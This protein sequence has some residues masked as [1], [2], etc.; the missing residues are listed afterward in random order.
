M[1]E[2]RVKIGSTH[3]PEGI[4]RDLQEAARQ[5]FHLAQA[6]VSDVTRIV[7]IMERETKEEE[8]DLSPETV[9]RIDDIVQQIESLIAEL[10]WTRRR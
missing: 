6:V 2:Y 5:G 4:E 7:L 3:A 1:I 10:S 9:E 8:A